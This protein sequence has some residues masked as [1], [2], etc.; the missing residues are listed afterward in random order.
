MKHRAHK[1]SK[2]RPH[3]LLVRAVAASM[4]EALLQALRAAGVPLQP[5]EL[6]RRV[7]FEHPEQA[8]F[9]SALEALEHEGSV[10]QNRR[11]ALCLVE[12]LDLI[13]GRVQGH[14][15]GYGFL[16]RED[17]EPDCFIGARQMHK[18]LHGDRVMALYVEAK[19]TWKGADFCPDANG[20]LRLTHGRVRRYQPRDGVVYTPITTLGG[21]VEKATGL[22]P[23]D[24]PE[25]LI[26]LWQRR[27]FGD[28]AHP[29]LGD[30]PVA[31]L[32]DTDTSGGNSGS[33][34]LNAKGDVVGVNFDRSFEATINDF[35]WSVDYSRSIGVDIR[36]VLWVTQKLMHADAVLEELRAR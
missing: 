15:D 14:A 11:G 10:M 21:V 18:V 7:G 26:K 20:T 31:I 36:Y 3:R 13:R 27:D 2:G 12:H 16:L 32:Y 30:V 35:Q 23:F 25:E 6:A 5:R 1:K 33:P 34:I 8:E 19:Q 29:E 4:S 17:G 22:E 28:F 9:Q 24:A